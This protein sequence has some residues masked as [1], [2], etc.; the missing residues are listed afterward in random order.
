M[1]RKKTLEPDDWK[2]IR[3]RRGWLELIRMAHKKNPGFSPSADLSK[4]SEPH[5]I[6]V[7]C[8]VASLVIGGWLWERLT[9][10]IDQIVDR[11]RH[12]AAIRVAAH[13]GGRVE[14]N[15]DGSLTVIKPDGKKPDH[16]T[17][18]P[19]LPLPLPTMFN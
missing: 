18:P 10:H 6:H 5:L 1:G 2:Q 8:Q 12:D 16:A 3:V 13:F 15:R 17:V 19:P 14:T 9:P 4:A 7:A 11:A